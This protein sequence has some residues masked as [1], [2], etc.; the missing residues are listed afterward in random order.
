MANE[1]GDPD[2]DGFTAE[3]AS[4]SREGLIQLFSGLPLLE[5]LVLDVC[6]NV[7]DSGPVLEVLKSKC[8]S[9]KVLKL[10]QFHGVC[11]AIGWQLDGVSLCGGLES[12]S[13]KNCGDL[14]D[15]G[16]VAIGR[17]CRRLVKFELE[18]CKNVTVDGLRT[19]AA[20][21]R[22]TLVEMKISCCKQ[23]GAV[24][25][26]KALDLVRDRSS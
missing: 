10:G 23:L 14:S 7:R 12:L 15:M 17:G 8:S 9:L 1:R 21:R 3:D 25:S 6:K 5:E 16:L 24:A 18:G 22:E 2:S 13:I 26:C 4:V 19:M 20:L 11:L